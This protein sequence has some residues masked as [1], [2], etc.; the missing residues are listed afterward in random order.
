[1]RNKL[2]LATEYDT[3]YIVQSQ[4]ESPVGYIEQ[5]TQT[6]SSY[7]SNIA[8]Y[9]TV[10]DHL[11]FMPTSNRICRIGGCSSS[12]AKARAFNIA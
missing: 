3:C 5:Q 10:T 2:W 9:M 11:P 4:L 6:V 1:M 7:E 8:Q 12:L